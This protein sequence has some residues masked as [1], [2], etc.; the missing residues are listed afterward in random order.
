M[1]YH[2]Q[3]SNE[4]YFLFHSNKFKRNKY[5]EQL[6]QLITSQDDIITYFINQATFLIFVTQE[7]DK[8]PHSNQFKFS[9]FWSSNL[10]D[11]PPLKF[12]RNPFSFVRV[13]KFQLKFYL[14][15][16][17]GWNHEIVSTSNPPIWFRIDFFPR[18]FRS[19]SPSD[20]FT[21]RTW[22]QMTYEGHYSL[23]IFPQIIQFLRQSVYDWIQHW[24]TQYTHQIHAWTCLELD[25]FVDH[26]WNCY[27]TNLK[28]VHLFET[29]ELFNFVIQQTRQ[30]NLFHSFASSE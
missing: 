21:S 30:H 10:F 18:F 22:D 1:P 12:Y 2:S 26:N 23:V 13:P 4:N 19:E 16:H 6:K 25:T 20:F 27:L 3:K 29:T 8:I 11:N 15:A 24:R 14:I 7:K 17:A 9:K 5:Y 28:D